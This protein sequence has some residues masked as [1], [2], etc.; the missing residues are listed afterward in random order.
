MIRFH[1]SEFT[2][3]TPHAADPHIGGEKEVQNIFLQEGSDPGSWD[4]GCQILDVLQDPDPDPR[5]W[6]PGSRILPSC[7]AVYPGTGRAVKV[8]KSMPECT[9][10]KKKA[11]RVARLDP[12]IPDAGSPQV[13]IPDPPGIPDPRSRPDPG[14]QILSCGA[15]FRRFSVSFFSSIFHT[16][17]ESV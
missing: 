7:P 17:L 11:P 8:L 15:G 6:H 3:L 4:P 10:S 5:S 14:S 13:P 9:F 2:R 16:F 12:R 1:F